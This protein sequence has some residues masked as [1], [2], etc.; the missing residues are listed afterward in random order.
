M[1]PKLQEKG[2]AIRLRKQGYSYPQISRKLNVS[3]SSLSLWLRTVSIST[4]AK[5]KINLR[6]VNAQKAG[7]EARR[8]QRMVKV[9]RIEDEAISQILHAKEIDVF[10]MGIMLYWAEGSKQGIGDPSQGV[11]FTNSDPLMCKFFMKWLRDCIFVPE[12]NIIPCVYIHESKKHLKD[13]AVSFWANQINFPREKLI[14]VYFTKT[15]YPRKNKRKNSIRYFGQLRIN[16][17]KSTDLNRRIAGWTKGICI[18]SG[19]ID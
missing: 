1:L 4:K 19:V 7:A 18:K 8:N 16:V 5:E 3:E 12:E 13:T 9:K 11:E 2:M 6:F 10:L 15:V 17:R 14:K